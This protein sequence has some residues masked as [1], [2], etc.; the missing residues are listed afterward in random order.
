MACTALA[1]FYY[2]VK[3]PELSESA[4]TVAATVKKADIAMQAGR[5]AE[6]GSLLD[7]ALQKMPEDPGILHQRAVAY[8]KQSQAAAALPLLNKI[9]AKNPADQSA[10]LDRASAEYMTH[11]YGAALRDYESILQSKD[12]AYCEGA[13]LGRALCHYSL[14]QYE[15]SIHQCREITAKNPR[16]AKALELLAN[17]YLGSGNCRDAVDT[18]TRCLRLEPRADYYWGRALAYLKDQRPA[19]AESDLKKAVELAPD[20]KEYRSKLAKLTGTGDKKSH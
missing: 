5:Y 11:A 17:S 3:A 13:A 19:N 2:Q 4:D 9:L 15:L 12:S 1:Y 7:G 20:N 10:L 14:A 6:A 8:L 16:S 18:Y